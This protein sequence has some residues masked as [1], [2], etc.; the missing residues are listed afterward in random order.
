MSENNVD[1]AVVG[2]A[3]RFPGAENYN[4]YWENLIKGKNCIIEIPHDRWDWKEYYG[5]PRTDTNKTNIIW[6]GFIEDIDKFDPL[7]FNISPKEAACI[8]PQHR[9]FLQ[10][11]WHSI[12][13]AGYSIESL[14]GKRI[15]IYA[16]VSKND[17]S[18]LMREL[19]NEIT[20][21][22]STGT[23][24]SIL[25]NRLSFLFD[26]HGRSEAIDTAC[27]SS[28]VALHNAMRDISNG[29]CEAALVGGV[30]ALLAPTMFISHSKS[31][32]LSIDGRCKTF[33]SEANGYV[34]G[35]GVGVLF[36][37]PL[38]QAME[39]GDNI[40]AVIKSSAV[41]HGGRA[42]FLTSPTVEAQADVIS[43]ALQRANIDPA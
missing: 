33:D 23:V 22:I 18:E 40:H 4:Q 35:E 15:G 32:M 42:N 25:A 1:F 9:L 2:M 31:G 27:P 14:A 6:G 24:H 30:N 12:E 5:D 29:E 36:I 8:D 43:T 21:F 3:C 13:D 16:G 39:A 37:K 17:Y 38:A 26:F 20:P 10:A 34:R 41:N 28:L 19:R 11:A 7:F